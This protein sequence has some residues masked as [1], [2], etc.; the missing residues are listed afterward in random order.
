MSKVHLT[1]ILRH[2]C[3]LKYFMVGDE[4]AMYSPHESDIR[5]LYGLIN[6]IKRLQKENEEL[7]KKVA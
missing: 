3:G 5:Q 7:K 6:E 1:E 4:M 2:L